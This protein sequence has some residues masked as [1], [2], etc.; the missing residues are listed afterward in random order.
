[1]QY[2]CKP[3]EIKVLLT[4]IE[5]AEPVSPFYIC[6]VCYKFHKVW[7]LSSIRF[8]SNNYLKLSVQMLQLSHRCGSV[9]TGV[10]VSCNNI[11]TNGIVGNSGK[12]GRL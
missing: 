3:F 4:E 2:P 6:S 8:C 5:G 1:M 11:I 7:N 12:R 10:W 9:V